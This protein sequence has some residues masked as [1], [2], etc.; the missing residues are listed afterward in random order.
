MTDTE[1]L[2]NK[3]LKAL[4]EYEEAQVNKIT[5]EVMR[6]NDKYIKVRELAIKRYF[7]AVDAVS[8]A[9]YGAL[10]EREICYLVATELRH[11]K[12]VFSHEV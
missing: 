7:N 2:F 6:N 8:K 10:S 5:L 1:Y 11:L 12:A 3:A 9:L 4:E